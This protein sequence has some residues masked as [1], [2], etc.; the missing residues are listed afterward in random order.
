MPPYSV[1][2]PYSPLCPILSQKSIIHQ[3]IFNLRTKW[4]QT[5]PQFASRS[6]GGYDYYRVVEIP[7]EQQQGYIAQSESDVLE[8]ENS[9]A[10]NNELD[11]PF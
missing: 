9:D 7:F 10:V 8:Q 2:Q 4:N 3:I 11:L 5:I 1:A 6:R